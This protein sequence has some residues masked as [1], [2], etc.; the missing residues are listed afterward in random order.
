MSALLGQTLGVVLALPDDDQDEIARAMLALA[1]DGADI[2][3][4]EPTHLAAVLEG[5]DQAR[6]GQFTASEAVDAAFTRFGR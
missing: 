6:R 4:I 3:P 5:L 2:E 1:G